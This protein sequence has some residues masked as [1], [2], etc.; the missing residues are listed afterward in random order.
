MRSPALLLLLPLLAAGCDRLDGEGVYVADACEEQVARQL[1]PG[2]G[3]ADAWVRSIV[4]ADVACADLSASLSLSQG[5]EEVPGA[6]ETAH[7]GYQVRFTPDGFI[8][9]GTTYDAR[10]DTTAGFIEWQF[11]TSTL[12]DPVGSDL[13]ERALAL[14]PSRAGVLEPAGFREELPRLI[15]AA[16]HPVLQ[17]QGEPSGGGVALRIGGRAEEAVASEQTPSVVPRDIVGGWQDPR[18]QGGPVDL[19]FPG[20][21]WAL[22]FEDAELGGAVAPGV[23]GGGGGSF[24][25]RWDLREVG[26]GLGDAFASPCVVNTRSG[27]EG[28]VPCRDGA[29]ACLPVDLRDV[30]AEAWG[31]L[32]Q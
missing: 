28:C 32:L 30:P 13:S 2:G 27:G 24:Q 12:G 29:L 10:L 3:A 17:F 16:M 25:G 15:E 23:A 1:H 22:V 9:P 6:S 20:G 26:D 31:W 19:R 11:E 14:F 18:W 7:G 5:G 8:Q 4:W 21:S